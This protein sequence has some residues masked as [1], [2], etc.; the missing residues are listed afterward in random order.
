MARF[1]HLR[2]EAEECFLRLHV[3]AWARAATFAGGNLVRFWRMAD[4][5]W[6][7]DFDAVLAAAVPAGSRILD[8]G[9]GDGGLV[10]RLAELGFD[11]FGVDPAAPSHPRLVPVPVED[12]RL[13]GEFDAVAAVMALHHAD[14]DAV[15]RALANLL[16]PRGSV[17]IYEFSWDA[18]DGRA[19]AWL[20]KHDLS[21]ADNS[22]AGW[23]REHSEL[24]TTATIK[25]ALY[26]RFE[27]VV[28]VRRPYLARMLGRA[29]LEATEHALIDAQM[30][31][32]LGLWTIARRAEA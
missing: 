21:H 32:A 18:Y 3:K 7:Q 9:C 22:V 16:R 2:A 25:K 30:L 8:V 1:K 14:L 19:A 13:L 10:D 23:R 27:P 5:R 26:A 17:F 15:V 11:V 24:H 31:P 20:A 4:S 29:D 12:A 6:W 28:E